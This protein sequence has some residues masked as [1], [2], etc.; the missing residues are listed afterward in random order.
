ML[1][2]LQNVLSKDSLR[3]AMVLTVVQLHFTITAYCC[4]LQTIVDRTLNVVFCSGVILDNIY[5]MLYS[6]LSAAQ[7][8]FVILLM[9]KGT[10][11]EAPVICK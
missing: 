1:Y 8:C 2:S 4:M 7:L 11:V 5:C 9:E 3:S 6:I 10:V